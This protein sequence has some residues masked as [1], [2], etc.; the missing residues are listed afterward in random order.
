VEV[1]GGLG[2]TTNRAGDPAPDRASQRAAWVAPCLRGDVEFTLDGQF[3]DLQTITG[4]VELNGDDW[5]E[6]TGTR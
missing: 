4:D 5:G 6:F 1:A 2:L 3:E